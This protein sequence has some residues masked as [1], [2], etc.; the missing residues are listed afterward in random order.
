MSISCQGCICE[1]FHCLYAASGRCAGKC[2]EQKCAGGI[3]FPA[4]HCEKY[5]SYTGQKV[6]E[7]LKAVVSVFQD[8]Y[9][10]CS[11]TD[12]FGCEKCYEEF[13]EREAD[14]ED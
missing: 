4:Q 12:N 7:C 8:G 6:K 1:T 10:L 2:R 13:A 11:L 5:V 9:I 3:F 14:H